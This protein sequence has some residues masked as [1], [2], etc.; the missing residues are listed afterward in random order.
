MEFKKG[1]IPWNKGLTKETDERVRLNG[2]LSGRSNKG[3]TPWNKGIPHTEETKRKI[4]EAKT[5]PSDE[6][7]RRISLNHADVSGKNNPNWGK[8]CSEE[9]RRKIGRGNKGKKRTPEERER[10]GKYWRGRKRSDES[11]EKKREFMLSDANLWRGRKHTKEAKRKISE[12]QR[13]S[14]GSN[15]KGGVTPLYHLIQGCVTYRLWREAIFTRDKFQCQDCGDKRG[16]NLNAHHKI[17]FVQLIQENNIVSLG[18]AIRTEALWIISNGI[19]LCEDCHKKRHKRSEQMKWLGEHEIMEDNMVTIKGE[20][21]HK[22]Y[23][24][25]EE[26]YK[27][28]LDKLGKEGIMEKKDGE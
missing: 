27:M 26:L 14:K 13:G 5:N 16:G 10:M 19:T 12:A 3:N 21:K 1:R 8:V 7:R 11:S 17:P 4:S 20:D 6:T 9:T 15:W 28:K 23:H 24:S 2:L 22:K 18:Q 25:W